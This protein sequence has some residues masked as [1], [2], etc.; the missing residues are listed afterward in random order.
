MARDPGRRRIG[1]PAIG[2]LDEAA[3]LGAIDL[4]DFRLVEARTAYSPADCGD[5]ID[6]TPLTGLDLML[7]GFFVIRAAGHVGTS[8]LRGYGVNIVSP[9]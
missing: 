4:A 3:V 5:P 9:F 1:E 2:G 6:R 7:A 8:C